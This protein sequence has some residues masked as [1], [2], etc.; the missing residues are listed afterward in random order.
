MEPG[1]RYL[2]PVPVAGDKLQQGACIKL[3]NSNEM[4]KVTKNNVIVS[5]A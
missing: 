5:Q 3:C 4:S 1:G 2:Q